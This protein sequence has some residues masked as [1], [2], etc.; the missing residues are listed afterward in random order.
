M[1]Q[2]RKIAFT[3]GKAKTDHLVFKAA[4]DV[5]VELDNPKQGI[6][7]HD[8][9]H[10][11]VERSFPF[12]GFLSLVFEGHDP[13]QTLEVIH[14]IAP[15]LV[16]PYPVSSWVTESLVESIQAC[17]WSKTED[18]DEFRYVFDKA[19]EARNIRTTKIDRED[20]KNCLQLIKRW[21]HDWEQ[22]SVGEKLVL[23]FEQRTES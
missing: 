18:F 2:D 6:L 9:I 14:G 3:R 17:L 21:S 13:S 20:F 5:V 4:D 19:C 1:S 10:L 12:K 23:P 8:M 7:P 11:A 22:I 15:K 16:E